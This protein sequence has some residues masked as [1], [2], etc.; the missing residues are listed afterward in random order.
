MVDQQTKKYGTT[1]EAV[2]LLHGLAANPFVMWPLQQH[3]ERS[4]FKTVNWGYPSLWRSIEW[5]AH[6]LRARIHNVSADPRFPRVHLVAHSMGGIVA[7]ST[8]ATGP[9]QQFG[10]IVTLASP[11]QGSHTATKLSQFIG[12]CKPLCQICDVED[13]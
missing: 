1:S 13:S 5:H 10:R 9:L 6:R 8:L 11:H 4:G 3:L 7:R 2:I 12:F